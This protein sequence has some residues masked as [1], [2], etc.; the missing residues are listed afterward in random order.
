MNELDSSCIFSQDPLFDIV[1]SD[2]VKFLAIVY[3][4]VVLRAGNAF[5]SL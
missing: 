3:N 1:L 5:I 4:V 2:I